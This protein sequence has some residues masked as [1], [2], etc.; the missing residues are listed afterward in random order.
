MYVGTAVKYL[1]I[2]P[3]QSVLLYFTSAAKG[4]ADNSGEIEI[5]QLARTDLAKKRLR[6]RTDK[7][8]DVAVD[9]ERGT[10]QDGD[11]LQDGKKSILVRQMPELVLGVRLAGDASAESLI[12]LGHIIGNMHRPI[13]I[14]GNTAYLPIQAESELETFENLLSVVPGGIELFT[15]RMVWNPRAGADVSGHAS[16]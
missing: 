12:L 3:L 6:R 8:T 9:L 7:G 2:N 11:I 15:K 16:S 13:S 5:L 4:N 1:T 10:L 14:D